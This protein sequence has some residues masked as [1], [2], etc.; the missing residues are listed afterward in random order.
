VVLR[1]KYKFMDLVKGTF[2]SLLVI[3]LATLPFSRGEPFSWLINLYQ[4]KIL[5][6]QLQIITANAF[7]IWTTITSIN[8]Q[9]QRFRF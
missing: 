2:I 1:Q 4:T 8:E 7:N 5:G 9:P 3:G 6:Q